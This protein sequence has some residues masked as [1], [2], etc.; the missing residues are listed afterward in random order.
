MNFEEALQKIKEN[1]HLIGSKIAMGTI[2]E[3]VIY[4]NNEDAK[5]IFIDIYSKTLNATEAIIPFLN[6]DVSISAIINKKAI[7]QGFFFTSNI[8]EIKKELEQQ[9]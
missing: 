4:P 5:I 8:E 3:L 9:S 7:K 2:D 1:S 6:E